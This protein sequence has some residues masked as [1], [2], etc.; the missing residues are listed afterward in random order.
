M[1]CV[2]AAERGVD[3]REELFGLFV[4]VQRVRFQALT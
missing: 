4:S 3:L 2:W 1:E